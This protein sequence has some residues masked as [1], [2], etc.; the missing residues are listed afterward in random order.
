[1]AGY[2]EQPAPYGTY[3]EPERSGWGRF[4][5]LGCGCFIVLCVIGAVVALIIID[6][7]CAWRHEPLAGLLDLLGVQANQGLQAC[8]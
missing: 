3:E 1:M 5:L 6:Q 2:G 4:L 8:Q 7:T